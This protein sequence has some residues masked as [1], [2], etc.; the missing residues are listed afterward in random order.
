[1]GRVGH[2]K[3]HLVSCVRGLGGALLCEHLLGVTCT[4][5]ALLQKVRIM[6]TYPWSAVTNRTYPLS[7]HWS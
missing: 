1:L 3:R 6:W 5:S 7:L 4:M 2:D